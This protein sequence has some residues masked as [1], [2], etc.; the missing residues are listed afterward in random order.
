[1]EEVKAR[2]FRGIARQRRRLIISGPGVEAKAE[3]GSLILICPGGESHAGLPSCRHCGAREGGSGNICC[4]VRR[5]GHGLV[6]F[7]EILEHK[8]I[9]D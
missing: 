2:Q 7:V 8:S 5:L 4:P 3:E 9:E 6:C 1:M